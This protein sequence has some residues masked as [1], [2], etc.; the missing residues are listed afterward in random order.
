MRASI[1]AV[2][3]YQRCVCVYYYCMYDITSCYVMLYVYIRIET[4]TRALYTGPTYHSAATHIRSRFQNHWESIIGTVTHHHRGSI[5][6]PTHECIVYIPCTIG[7]THAVRM[8]R[9]PYHIY[10]WCKSYDMIPYL[11]PTYAGP[12]RLGAWPWRRAPASRRC[13]S[14]WLPR[15]LVFGGRRRAPPGT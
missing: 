12:R 4:A 6:C 8:Y 2:P 3:L 11:L 1:T 15:T 13:A 5:S 14:G 7:T 9:I 10:L